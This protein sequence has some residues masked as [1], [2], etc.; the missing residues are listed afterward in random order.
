MALTAI[1]AV[2]ITAAA[3]DNETRDWT[4]TPIRHVVVIFDENVSFDHYF[5]TYPH[6]ANPPGEPTFR[7]SPNTPVVN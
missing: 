3:Q 1:T 5:A 6:A 4:R 2:G 7:H